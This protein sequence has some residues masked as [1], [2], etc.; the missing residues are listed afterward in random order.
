[1][2]GD[3]RQTS[4]DLAWLA[5]LERAPY[6]FGFYTV[7]RRF[8]AQYRQLPRLGYAP[9]PQGEP[10]RIG[11]NPSLAFAA[12]TLA[13]FAQGKAGRPAKLFTNFFGLLGP[14]GPLPIHLTEHAYERIVRSR[15][16]TFAAFLDVFHHRLALYFYR[17]WA[18]AQ[19]TVQYDRPEQ[20]RFAT[21]VGS[22]IG[23]GA[24]AFRNRDAM[25]DETKLHFAGHLGVQGRHAAGL[26]SML[27][28]FLR[29][30]V[31]LE[32]FVGEW[33]EVP[34][35]CRL[36]LRSDREAAALGQSAVLGRRIWDRRQS[37]GL[38][39]GPMSLAAYRRLLP[40]G[41]TLRRVEAVIK[42][43][44][45]LTFRWNIR[46]VLRKEEVPQLE[47]GRGGQLGWSTWL[48]SGKRTSDARDLVLRSRD[49][50]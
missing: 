8:E 48:A 6:D 10:V 20:D 43:Y 38:T 32:Q 28:A 47:L 27:S 16:R 35:D 30:P 3:H 42:N 22:L 39:F 26:R 41:D 1:M 13:S 14:N 24:A 18:D 5:R 12:A 49:A 33:I 37:F 29:V 44:V 21:Y 2:A 31:E 25:P 4:A 7:L 46:L 40:G 17:A 9:R 15:D 19:P 34:S 36:R 11:Q 23:I 50:A 45:G